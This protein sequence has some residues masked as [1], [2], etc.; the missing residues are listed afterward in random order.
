MTRGFTEEDIANIKNN[1][2][3]WQSLLFWLLPLG[4]SL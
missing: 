1:L 3:L 2:Q 4:F